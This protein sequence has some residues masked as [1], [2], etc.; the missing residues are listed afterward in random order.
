LPITAL[1][2]RYDTS[3][4]RKMTANHVA[5]T[6][7]R[8][9]ANGPGWSWRVQWGTAGGDDREE[10]GGADTLDECVDAVRRWW[11]GADED[12]TRWSY[13]PEDGGCYRL[14]V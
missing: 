12:L 10:S 8:D 14:P 9:R 3:E 1:G 7:Y 11:R 2:D 4:D 13:T 6:I 5:C